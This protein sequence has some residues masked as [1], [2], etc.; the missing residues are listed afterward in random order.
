MPVR[1]ASETGS[2]KVTRTLVEDASRAE[3]M[4][5][6]TLSVAG[7]AAPSAST[8]EP[9]ASS[10]ATPAYCTPG[11]AAVS[12]EPLSVRRRKISASLAVAPVLQPETT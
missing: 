11:V 4:T 9:S 1:L 2:E 7:A 8:V 5:G 12:I 3:L 6:P 10:S